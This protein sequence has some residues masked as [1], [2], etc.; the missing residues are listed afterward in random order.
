MAKNGNIKIPNIKRAD[1]EFELPFKKNKDGLF[2]PFPSRRFVGGKNCLRNL[3]AS[4]ITVGW[5]YL[6]NIC[7]TDKYKIGVSVNPKRRLA[8]ISSALPFELEL[9]AINEVNDPFQFEQS[10]IDKFKS[11]LI[12]NE[13]FTLNVEDVKYI[14]VSLHNKQVEDSIYG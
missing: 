3:A 12:K 7:D 6:I 4:K 8:D 2:R 10:L 13:W 9:M 5:I 11:K 14:M 1:I